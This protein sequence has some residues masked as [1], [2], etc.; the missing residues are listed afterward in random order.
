MRDWF[1]LLIAERNKP[2]VLHTPLAS[3]CCNGIVSAAITTTPRSDSAVT[4]AIIAIDTVFSSFEWSVI[5]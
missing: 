2:G 1:P 3:A 5:L 4:I